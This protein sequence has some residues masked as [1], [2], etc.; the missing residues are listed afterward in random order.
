MLAALLGVLLWPQPE[1]R[2]R[3]SFAARG[4]V[5]GR[6]SQRAGHPGLLADARRRIGLKAEPAAAAETGG[7]AFALPERSVASGIDAA[8]AQGFEVASIQLPLN[9]KFGLAYTCGRC[10][11]RNAIQVTRIAWKSGIVIATCRGCKVRHLLADNGGLLDLTNDTG[12]T[13]IVE[14]IEAQGNRVTKLDKFDAEML[15][16]LNLTVDKDGKLKLSE[17]GLAFNFPPAG[18]DP[19]L[20]PDSQAR[21]DMSTNTAAVFDSSSAIED[22]MVEAAPL[23]VS[24]PVGAKKGDILTLSSDFG[25]MLVPVPDGATDGCTLEVQGMVEAGLGVGHGRWLQSSGGQEWAMSEEWKVG[26]VVAVSMP[27]GAVIRITIPESAARDG[28]LRIAYP[29]VVLPGTH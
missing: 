12:F 22:E 1:P 24:V 7:Q 25:M 28:T 3:G 19:P 9:E 27:E 14:F 13:N 6:P 29:V 4:Q 5:A 17:G 10:N 16:E 15:R 11:V 18:V 8:A 20:K 21:G 2:C 23:L 26:D